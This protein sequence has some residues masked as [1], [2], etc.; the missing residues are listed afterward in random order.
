[1]TKKTK[2]IVAAF[3]AIATIGIGAG[4]GIAAGG[5]DDRALTGSARER[6]SDAALEHVGDGTVIETEVGDD[7]A[8]YEVE[9]R[10]ADGRQVEVELDANFDVIGT[11]RDDDGPNDSDADR[12]DD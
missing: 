4:V 11:E 12:N 7:G 3:A 6:A 9:I 10:L 1:M 2:W 8:P 5:D